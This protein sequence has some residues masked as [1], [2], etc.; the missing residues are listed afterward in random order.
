MEG[1]SLN[2]CFFLGCIFSLFKAGKKYKFAA[3]GCKGYTKI[4]LMALLFSVMIKIIVNKIDY[5]C[6][7]FVRP[8]GKFFE[9][10][11][12][13]L[14]LQSNFEHIRRNISLRFSSLFLPF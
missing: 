10:R 12:L 13:K 6:K 8:L 5:N 7:P 3:R 9:T 2:Y 4:A 14:L 11:V 1:R